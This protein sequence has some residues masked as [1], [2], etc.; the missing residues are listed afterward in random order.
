MDEVINKYFKDDRVMFFHSSDAH[1]MLAGDTYLRYEYQGDRVIL[2][3][4]SDYEEVP[5]KFC[6]SGE[7]LE[8]TSS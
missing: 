4:G 7:E 8:G 2:W 5:L 3:Y 1:K 6:R